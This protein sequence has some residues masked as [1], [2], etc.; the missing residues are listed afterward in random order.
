MSIDRKIQTLI[1]QA[2]QAMIQKGVPVVVAEQAA[3][4]IQFNLLNQ[5]K[6]VANRYVPKVDEIDGW[7]A[8]AIDW[9]DHDMTFF[10]QTSPRLGWFLHGRVSK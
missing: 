3:N 5:F 8:G 2:Y 7:L 4:T 1:E 10:Q 9:G 6:T